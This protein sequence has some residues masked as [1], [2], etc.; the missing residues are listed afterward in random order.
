M[1]LKDIDNIAGNG[2]L[3]CHICNEVLLL[4]DDGMK[5]LNARREEIKSLA[6]YPVGGSVLIASASLMH[7]GGFLPL[8]LLLVCYVLAITAMLKPHAASFLDSHLTFH[9]NS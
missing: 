4:N 6:P 8:D 9:D 1:P 2:W 5:A 7:F 3:N